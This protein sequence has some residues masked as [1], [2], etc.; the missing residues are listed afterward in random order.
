MRVTFPVWWR[1]RREDA[2]GRRRKS[3][4]PTT[5]A[6]KEKRNNVKTNGEFSGALRKCQIPVKYYKI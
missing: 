5:E 3:I 4:E 2:T 6:N 1:L